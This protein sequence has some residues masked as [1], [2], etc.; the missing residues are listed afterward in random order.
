MFP[1]PRPKILALP[2][3]AIA[4]PNMVT[5]FTVDWLSATI[6]E[7][8]NAKVFDFVRAFDDLSTRKIVT[9]IHGYDTAYRWKFGALAL[10]HSRRPEMGTHFILSGSALRYLHEAGL[11]GI[12]LI[13]RFAQSFA[14]F[15]MIHLA[16]DI[17]DSSIVPSEF[18]DLFMKK[19][20]TGRAR[21]ASVIQNSFG[22]Q[23]LYVGSW[24]SARF[25][26]LYDKAAEQ[27]LKGI[28]WKRLELILKQDYAQEFGYRFAGENEVD[29]AVSVFKGVIQ[30]MA[31]FNQVDFIKAME[32]KI[33][34]LKLPQHKERKTREWILTQV[35]PAMARYIAETGDESLV[36]DFREE[37]DAQMAKEMKKL[38]QG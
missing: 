26:R 14:K 9:A 5:G 18:Y 29:H 28:N 7:N 37:F 12:F 36:D 20:Y 17:N 8:K 23:T 11:D 34:S 22:G 32:G 15:T 1:M 25:F 38:E 19:Q 4:S 13:R 6:K 30:Q 27:G 24:D 2:N 31:K 21:N 10:W 16:L 3:D 33:E 35:V